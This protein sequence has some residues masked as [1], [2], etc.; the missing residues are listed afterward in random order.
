MD[1]I[2]NGE[3]SPKQAFVCYERINLFNH[4]DQT[5]FDVESKYAKI[6][7]LFREG[8]NKMWIEGFWSWEITI[9][10][11]GRICI[12]LQSKEGNKSTT[13]IYDLPVWQENTI[14]WFSDEK[15]SIAQQH[16]VNTMKFDPQTATQI[17]N[18][19]IF[20]GNVSYQTIDDNDIAKMGGSENFKNVQSIMRSIW[21]HREVLKFK[22]GPTEYY[23]DPERY[24]INPDHNKEAT[25]E[26]SHIKIEK[27]KNSEWNESEA[28]YCFVKRDRD[29]RYHSVATEMEA[30]FNDFQYTIKIKDFRYNTEKNGYEAYYKKVGYLMKVYEWTHED[31]QN[32]VIQASNVEE[33]HDSIQKE[34]PVV[35]SPIVQTQSPVASS[36]VEA[37]SQTQVQENPS[38]PPVQQKTSVQAEDLDFLFW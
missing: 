22:I 29:W 37:S 24:K 12:N 33:V 4:K 35:G 9:A 15:R 14:N 17:L 30:S 31:K 6:Q 11:D 8:V 16:L 13:W 36:I 26:P 1:T 28:R 25:V 5:F 38:T 10:Q 23:M 20:N 21:W 7:K 19:I 34:V 18:K 32:T 27:I 2:D 3:V